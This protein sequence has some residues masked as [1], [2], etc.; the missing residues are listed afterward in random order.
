MAREAL[1]AEVS[2]IGRRS[3]AAKDDERAHL[4]ET[5]G[6]SA[7]DNRAL[8]DVGMRKKHGLDLE[9]RDPLRADAEHV[10]VAAKVKIVSVRDAVAVPGHDPAIAE[11][12]GR[13]LGPVVVTERGR[14]AAHP[15]GSL[16]RLETIRVHDAGFITGDD[17]AGR[18]RCHVLG[19]IRDRDVADLGRADPVEDPQTE[20]PVPPLGQ[21]RR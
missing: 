18:S 3:G 20:T 21:R 4:D 19:A 15:E 11:R 6:I 14:A 1:G 16:A 9:R 12:R 7:T 8:G 5:V 10:V 13:R 2:E 17:P